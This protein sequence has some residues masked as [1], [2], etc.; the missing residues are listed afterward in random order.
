MKFFGKKNE[1]QLD[2]DKE[3]SKT[4]AHPGLKVIS[5]SSV[6]KSTP[7]PKQPIPEPAD[8]ELIPQVELTLHLL[9]QG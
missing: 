4:I 9:V 6:S 5:G 2:Q 3:K 8:E 1:E 7:T